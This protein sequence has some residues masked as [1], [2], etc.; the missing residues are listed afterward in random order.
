MSTRKAQSQCSRVVCVYNTA[1]Y[2]STIAVET[3]MVNLIV[4]VD[5]LLLHFQFVL[6]MILYIT[7]CGAGYMEKPSLDFLP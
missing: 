7:T 6:N 4:I 2:G 5:A 1:L 3:W